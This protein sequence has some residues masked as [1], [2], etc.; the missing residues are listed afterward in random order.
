MFEQITKTAQRE[1]AYRLMFYFVLYV[2]FR[3]P[4]AVAK[5][6]KQVERVSNNRRVLPGNRLTG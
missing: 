2:M 3:A 1:Q 4:A 5:A 6:T